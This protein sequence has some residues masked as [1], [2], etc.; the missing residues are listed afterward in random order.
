M[1]IPYYKGS[2]EA[3]CL[4]KP[5]YDLILGNIPGVLDK[6]NL[7]VAGREIAAVARIVP[8]ER[9]ADELQAVITRVQ[10]KKDKTDK[11]LN[12]ASI[13]DINVPID[14][15]KAMQK[16]DKT[17]Q[18]LW[19]KVETG[20]IKTGDESI[21]SFEMK[22]GLLYRRR[23]SQSQLVIPEHCE[24]LQR[25][26]IMS[27]HF[28]IKKTYDRILSHFFWPGLHGDVS[29]YCKSCA[30]CHR[31]VVKGRVT[32]V[33]LGNMPLIETHFQRVA[34]DLI[35][36]IAL[37][38]EINRYILSLVDHA[39]RYPEAAIL[40]NIEAETVAEALVTVYMGRCPGR[41]SFRSGKPVHEFSYEGC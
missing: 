1:D 38:E 28:G 16:S 3:L 41:S 32:K 36:P 9:E 30:I 34:V 25:D 27:G 4:K 35:G 20:E 15:M 18:T 8:E 13:T 39:I 26:S 14:S 31:T 2:F 7:V 11:P 24:K 21:V 37:T 12:V 22:H 23:T 40:K 17:P 6:P 10:A 5:I 29:R 33:P 19:P